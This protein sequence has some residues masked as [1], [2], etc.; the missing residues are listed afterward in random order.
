[1][2][3]VA[4]VAVSTGLRAWAAL[5]IP[6]LWIL[7]DEAIYGE[8]AKSIWSGRPEILGEPAPFYGVVYP[9]VAGVPLSLGDLRLGYDL[10]KPLQALVMSLAA[11]PVFFWGRSLMQERWALAAAALSLAIPGL[12][13][14]GLLMTEVAFY[15]VC[16]LA[17]WLLARALSRPTMSAQALAVAGL[18]VAAATRL[19]A[20]VLVPAFLTAVGVQAM[21]NRNLRVAARLWPAYAALGALGAAWAGWR[22]RDGGPLSKVLG[23]YQAAGEAGYDP[24]AA[25]RWVVYHAGDLLILV[26]VVPAVAV[27]VLLA[28]AA[29]GR[30]RDSN[31]AA[32]LAVA[33]SCAVWFVL[34]V[35][36]FA[37]RN[38][39]RL[40]ERDLLPL[41]P[42]LFLGLCAW[43]DRGAPRPRVASSLSAAAALALVAGLPLGTLVSR[44]ALPDAFTL[45]P[46]WRLELH[47]SGGVL[48]PLAIVLAAGALAAFLFLPRRRAWLLAAVIGVGLAAVSVSASRVVAG[49]ATLVRSDTTGTRPTWI[50]DAGSGPTAILYGGETNWTAVWAGVFWNRRVE[51]VYV[52]LDVEVPGPLPQQVVGPYDDGRLGLPDGTTAPTPSFAV[53]PSSMAVVGDPVAAARGPHLEL[54][55]TVAPFRLAQWIRGIDP[56]GWIGDHGSLA[57]Y[58][59]DGG[60]LRLRLAAPGTTSVELVRN[61]APFRTLTLAPGQAATARIPADPPQPIGQLACT[62]DIL[63]TA[64]VRATRLTF[65]R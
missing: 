32:Y 1:V 55:R 21:L 43:L 41:A 35:G 20:L 19:Q 29:A 18:A 15:P 6:G 25:A 7:P 34:E 54:W 16:L 37:S 58:A 5:R 57:V 27:A 31:L 17:S 3:L 11:V 53:A 30:D 26:G 4:L 47:T 48:R 14:A 65:D 22:L 9:L 8:L 24:G 56:G 28:E 2:L 33:C 61:G 46:L 64:P 51:R 13:Y 36:V 50:D 12:A 63:P 39:G 49:Q 38:I 10:L 40:A 45:A 44:A 23:A 60:L 52:L 62:F 42:L 59:C